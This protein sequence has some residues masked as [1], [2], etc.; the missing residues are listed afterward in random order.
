MTELQNDAKE[1]E[2]RQS[3]VTKEQ[4]IQLQKLFQTLEEQK[5]E[6]G[7]L[8]LFMSKFSIFFLIDIF[9][10]S[11]FFSIFANFQFFLL[12]LFFCFDEKNCIF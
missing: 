1:N 11:F 5:C 3:E 2:K 10:F 7:K 6:I 8:I 4:K 9:F 12:V